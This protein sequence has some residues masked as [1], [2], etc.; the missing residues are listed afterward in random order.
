VVQCAALDQLHGKEGA[1]VGQGA[2]VVNRRDARVLQLG[3]DARLVG[4][5]AGAGR[6][7]RVAVLEQL[8]G[9]VPVEGEVARLVDDAHAAA[10]DLAGQFVPGYLRQVGGRGHGRDCAD[11]RRRP[12]AREQLD[13]GRV[14]EAGLPPP[15]PDFGEQFGAAAAHLFRRLPR[16]AHLLKQSEHPGVGGHRQSSSSEG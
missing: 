14:D 8:D 6:V 5:P 3:G 13:D 2:Q 1:A 4:E 11:S 15:L 16:V 9:H 7:G 10:A 12:K